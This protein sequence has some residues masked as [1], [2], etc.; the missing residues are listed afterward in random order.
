MSSKKTTPL[1]VLT[2][3]LGS[4]KTTILRALLAD[5]LEPVAVLVNEVGEL[6]LDHHLLERVDEDVLLLPG[7]C[8]CCE[9]RGDL[10]VALD[11]LLERRPARV[12]LETTGLT[13]PAPLLHAIAADAGLAARVELRGVIVAVDCERIEELAREQPEVR[14]QLDFADRVVLSKVDLAPQRA[15][16]VR[17]WLEREVPGREVRAADRGRLDWHWLLD[18]PGFGLRASSSVEGAR[19]WLW[20]PLAGPAASS[21][22]GRADHGSIGYTTHSIRVDDAVEIE[23]VQLWLRLVTQLDGPRLLR[24]KA[25]A[26]CRASGATYVLQSAGASVSPPQRLDLAPPDLAGAEVVVIER[27]MPEGSIEPLLRSL[28]EALAGHAGADRSP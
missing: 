14:R 7:G 18:R 15:Q 11:R 17:A 3:F 21:G 9:L 5:A 16:G 1:H 2:G 24:I 22:D 23:A 19:G 25:L 4:G 8:V 20:G 13:D 26:R 28:H 27:G 10:L 6:G 12:V